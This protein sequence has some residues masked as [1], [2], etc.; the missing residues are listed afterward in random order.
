M[1][2]VKSVQEKRPYLVVPVVSRFLR[3]DT[4]PL[5]LVEEMN[6]W[7]IRVLD[8]LPFISVE[9]ALENGI[10][11][12]KRI[13]G[14][15]PEFLGYLVSRRSTVALSRLYRNSIGPDSIVMPLRQSEEFASTREWQYLVGFGFLSACIIG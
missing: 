13:S 2:H 11:L 9:F 3:T 10:A 4:V 15:G 8:P 6:N 12:E 5:W 1:L 7:L 14:K